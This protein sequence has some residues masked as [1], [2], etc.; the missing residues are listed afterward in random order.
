MSRQDG[1]AVEE[2]LADTVRFGHLKDDSLRVDL[3]DGDWLAANNQEVALRGV[4]VFVKV[5]A[6]REED[7]IRIHRL[8]VGEFQALSEDEGICQSVG[9]DFPGFGQGSFCEL[10]GAV[11]V[12]EIGLH[13]ADDFAGSG[14]G[15]D[16]RIQGLWF[17]AERNNE[18]SAGAADFTGED[19]QFLFRIILLRFR[20]GRL[21]NDCGENEE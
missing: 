9:R 14:V 17:A 16:Q 19:K 13:N 2:P 11:D 3:S 6:K 12:D 8:A 4:S 15:G 5:D 7:I 10:G 18:A 20:K 21:A 1:H